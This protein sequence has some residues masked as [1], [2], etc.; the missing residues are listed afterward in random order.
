MLIM[1]GRIEKSYARKDRERSSLLSHIALNGTVADMPCTRC[2]RGNLTCRMA[3]KSNRCEECVRQRKSCDGTRVASSLEKL[4]S[5]QQKLDA[6]EEE[7]SENLLALHT[8]LAELQSQL[9]AAAGRLSR[10]RKIRSR[11]KGKSAE[12][13]ERG[14]R[15]LDAEDDLVPALDGHE[16][17]L[18]EDLQSIGVPN[19]VDWSS[20]GLG[21]EFE[22]LG[23]LVPGTGTPPERQEQSAS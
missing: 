8:Q 7:A 13:F 9:A 2:F 23:P 6:E 3:G 20:F 22:S 14:M 4:I 15:E 5:Q 11:V 21:L 10:I 12:L 18:V 17:A 16:Q 19:D 1:S